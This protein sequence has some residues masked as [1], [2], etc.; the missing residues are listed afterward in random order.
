M[1]LCAKIQLIVGFEMHKEIES[2]EMFVKLNY[3]PY[4]A[5]ELRCRNGFKTL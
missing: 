3:K 4:P 5:L 2:I 1:T